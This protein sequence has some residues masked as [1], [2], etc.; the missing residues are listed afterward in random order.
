M[1][2]I[3]HTQ[4]HTKTHHARR[5]IGDCEYVPCTVVTFRGRKIRTAQCREHGTIPK[6][7]MGR[8]LALA[9]IDFELR[10]D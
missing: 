4:A 10:W 5:Y 6:D 7:K 2:K 8:V 9:A 1:G 3:K